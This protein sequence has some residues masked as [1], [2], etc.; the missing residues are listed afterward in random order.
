MPSRIPGN[1]VDTTRVVHGASPM[2]TKPLVTDIQDLWRH[3]GHIFMRV[4]LGAAFCTSLTVGSDHACAETNRTRGPHAADWWQLHAP[5]SATWGAGFTRETRQLGDK[6]WIGPV[7]ALLCAV[8]NRTSPLPRI[9]PLARLPLARHSSVFTP[10]ASFLRAILSSHVLFLA[11]S[12]IRARSACSRYT[13]SHSTACRPPIFALP[14]RRS[15]DENGHEQAK[16]RQGHAC[17]LQ[18]GAWTYVYCTRFHTSFPGSRRTSGVQYSTLMHVRKSSAY[19][20]F[21]QKVG[22]LHRRVS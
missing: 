9:L 12:S 20:S 6:H 22:L 14:G 11:P 3:V 5:S 21:R 17:T 13:A 15:G 1:S 4:Y 18:W 2:V 7:I 16:T 8:T 19:M 10:W